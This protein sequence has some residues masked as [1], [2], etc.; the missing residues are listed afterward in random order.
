MDKNKVI[1]IHNAIR[2]ALQKVAQEHGLDK[3]DTRT[4][5]YS[6]NGFSV[7][8]EGTFAG[9]ES[10]EMRKLRAN[11]ALY[12]FKESICNAVVKY[13]NINLQIIGLR[14]NVNLLG[15]DVDTNK[16]YLVHISSLVNI[17]KSQNS[18]HVYPNTQ[19]I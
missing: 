11:Y 8:I 6:D 18:E 2:E 15:K 4:L 19:S 1:I 5:R 9:G 17:L 10:K 3:L 12:G 14:S 13:D 16:E 7:N